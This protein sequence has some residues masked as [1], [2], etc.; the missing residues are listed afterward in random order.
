MNYYYVVFLNIF[1]FI[2]FY[3]AF[4]CFLYIIFIDGVDDG[5]IIFFCGI[6]FA[7]DKGFGGFESG[8][9]DV[10][11]YKD[12]RFEKYL[13]FFF[14]FFLSDMLEEPVFFIYF[15]LA[16]IYFILFYFET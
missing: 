2:C 12:R 13:Y 14:V 8:S 5:L 9:Y 16:E 1:L 10:F 6:G 7:N 4:I 15:Y 11:Q 3:F